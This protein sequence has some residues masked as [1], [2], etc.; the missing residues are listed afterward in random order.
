MIQGQFS[1]LGMKAVKEIEGEKTVSSTRERSSQQNKGHLAETW[2]HQQRY[3]QH[4]MS[5]PP[6]GRCILILGVPLTAHSMAPSALLLF[7][8]LR[9]SPHRDMSVLTSQCSCACGSIQDLPYHTGSYL[10]V[11][12]PRNKATHDARGRISKMQPITLETENRTGFPTELWEGPEALTRRDQSCGTSAQCRVPGTRL[13]VPWRV[14]QQLFQ[15]GSGSVCQ[16][17]CT[18]CSFCSSWE[19]V[20]ASVKY[21]SN[22]EKLWGLKT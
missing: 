8:M 16:A 12:F 10:V 1:E 17:H 11:Q 7:S 15:P 5:F 22:P 18:G 6:A 21:Y 2:F 14:Y 19:E 13:M 20:C 9:R 3:Q 4:S